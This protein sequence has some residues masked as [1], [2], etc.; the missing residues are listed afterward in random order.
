MTHQ[1]ALEIISDATGEEIH[2]VSRI[3]HNNGY[4]EVTE[5]LVED[6]IDMVVD[7][8]AEVASER[9]MEMAMDDF[10]GGF[11]E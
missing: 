1:E 11:G 8:V 9:R 6:M 5:D 3:L 2:E 10:H 4:D 7:I